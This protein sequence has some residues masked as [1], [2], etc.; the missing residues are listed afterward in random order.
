MKHKKILICGAFAFDTMATGGQPVK[1]RELYYL[2]KDEYGVDDVDVLE[3]TTWKI[4]P[5]KLIYDFFNKAF[6][7]DII[8]ML[9]AHNGVLVFSS[10][11]NICR[12]LV[13]KKIYYDVIGGWLASKAE[14][15]KWLA[16]KLKKF[17][18]VWVETSSMKSDLEKLG[19]K[20]VYVF[21][22]FKNLEVVHDSVISNSEPH[23]LCI[24][25]RIMK[26]KGVTDAINAVMAIN[27]K[28]GRIIYLLD[29]YGPIDDSYKEEFNQ[30]IKNN[31]DRIT[32][33]GIVRP[34]DSVEVLHGYFALLF[35][36]LFYTEGIPGTIIDAF[37]AGVPVISS[38]WLNYGDIVEDGKTGFLYEFGNYDRFVDILD[39][40]ALNPER[41]NAL[42]QN[43][44]EKSEEFSTSSARQRLSELI[45]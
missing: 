11:L 23:K 12:C 39:Q 44:I 24:F 32:Y 28:Y 17:N 16:Y 37:Y 15:N 18:G 33:K 13:G 14:N 9:P 35:P 45:K 6:N 42:K 36:T 27:H 30:L 40:I 41:M 26:K 25:S 29:I 20:N 1:T 19:F 10:L 31:P 8:I 4:N 5:F 21:K 2:L 7:V 43:C 38:K 34:Q 22:N 3:I